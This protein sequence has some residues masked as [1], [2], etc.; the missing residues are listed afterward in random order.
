[1]FKLI[2]QD[3]YKIF[4]ILKSVLQ[5]T[6][7]K[8]KRSQDDKQKDLDY[9]SYDFD[10]LKDVSSDELTQLKSQL[11]SDIDGDAPFF[12]RAPLEKRLSKVNNELQTRASEDGNKLSDDNKKTEEKA[13]M[14]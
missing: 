11:K 4:K 8:Q 1:M 6:L 5:I 9:G 2:Q 10:N 14:I 3:P 12:L 13:K 7:L